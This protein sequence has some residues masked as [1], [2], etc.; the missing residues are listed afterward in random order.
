M[1][2]FA[3][4]TAQFEPGIFIPT[5]AIGAAVGRLAGHGVQAV[6][7][8]AGLQLQVRMLAHV[9][10][11]VCACGYLCVRV[12]ARVFVCLCLCVCVCVCV[13]VFVMVGIQYFNAVGT[14]A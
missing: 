9:R 8:A 7:L 6:L 2:P 5:M 12:C 10:A 3:H 1:L 11:C 4:F 13:C 14:L